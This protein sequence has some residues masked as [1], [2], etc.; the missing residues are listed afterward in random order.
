MKLPKTF[1]NLKFD[2]LKN[3]IGIVNDKISVMYNTCLLI[4]TF[5]AWRRQFST[6]EHSVGHQAGR[7]HWNPGTHVQLIL[8]HPV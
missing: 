5:L 7:Q 6:D 3:N 8:T 2:T 1:L 4:L